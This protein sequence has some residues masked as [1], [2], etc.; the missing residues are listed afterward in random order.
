M[1]WYGMVYINMCTVTHGTHALYCIQSNY[2]A[3]IMSSSTDSTRDLDC[4]IQ[5]LDSLQ[6]T[7][8]IHPNYFNTTKLHE[9]NQLYTQH[10]PFKLI[11]LHNI[12]EESYAVQLRSELLELE[13]YVKSNDLF[14]LMQSNDLANTADRAKPLHLLD[15]LFTTL[16]STEFMQS[17]YKLT[18]IKLDPYNSTVSCSA[19]VYSD[20]H[21]LLCHDDQLQSR[22]I[23]YIIYM[24][25]SSLPWTAQQGGTLDLYDI[26]ADGNPNMIVQSYTPEFNTM[27]LF[28]VTPYSYHRVAEV[29]KRIHTQTNQHNESVS[30]KQKLQHNDDGDELSEIHSLRLSISGWYHGSP[31]NYPTVKLPQQASL[32][33]PIQLHNVQLSD[34]INDV[35]LNKKQQKQIKKQFC[36]VSSVQ[37]SSFLLPSIYQ[38]LL[39][40]LQQS[41]LDTTT[42]GIQWVHVGPANW[43]HYQNA[44]FN[45]N[46]AQPVTYQLNQLIQS[47]PFILLLHKLTGIDIDTCQSTVRQFK[48]GDYTLAHDHD[49][50][51]RNEALDLNLCILPA[52]IEWSESYGGTIH[53]IGAG[54]TEEL[55]CIQPINNTLS[56]VYRTGV[57]SED[58]NDQVAGVLQFTKYINHH[59]PCTKYDIQALYRPVVQSSSSESSDEG[60]VD[61]KHNT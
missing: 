30:K 47:Q 39:H 41:E 11:Q 57:D 29:I 16:Y 61:Q 55:E 21:H 26:D 20:T 15:K 14:D 32:T 44:E 2:A 5:W 42:S 35:Y 22:R 50:E 58:N 28:E 4:A 46:T 48:H 18:G 27:I 37:L 56:L 24:I 52:D 51:I 10:T 53:Y 49:P 25:D 60:N 1:V 17:L 40:E 19:N 36:D 43:R 54:E 34:Y 38:Q 13:Y 45:N 3:S 12:L 7:D 31:I 9:L 23:A 6:V 59:A 33:Q 8:I